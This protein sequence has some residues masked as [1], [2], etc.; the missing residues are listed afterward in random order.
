MTTTGIGAVPAAYADLLAHDMPR[1]IRIWVSIYGV[2]EV[3]GPRHNPVI[4]DWAHVLTPRRTGITIDDDETPWCGLAMGW[5]ALS[6]G[7]EPPPI[8]VRAASWGWWGDPVREPDPWLGDVGV[9]HRPGGNHVGTVV[10]HDETHIHLMGA[11]QGDAVNI[12]RFPRAAF[13]AFRR[14]VYRIG[15]PPKAV[16]TLRARDGASAG[17]S[18]A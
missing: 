16:P 8:C 9:M 14:P 10:G 2:R 17:G 4:L 11:N 18:T 15:R 12:R 3:K 5:V 13:H 6:A 1:M 7:Y